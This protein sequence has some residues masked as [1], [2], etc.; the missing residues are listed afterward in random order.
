MGLE[1]LEILA[2]TVIVLSLVKLTVGLISPKSWLNFARKIYVKPQV[3]SAV[4]SVLAAVVLYVLVSSGMT[5]VHILAVTL[6]I[7]LILVVGIARYGDEIISWAMEQ[8]LRAMIK[9]HWLYALIWIALIAWGI[10]AIFTR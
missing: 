1:P 7:M 10:I 2:A 8:D 3:T 4:A 9:D 6:F 5:I